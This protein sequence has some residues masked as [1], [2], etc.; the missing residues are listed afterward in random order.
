[1][2]RRPRIFRLYEFQFRTIVTRSMA[3]LHDLGEGG[4]LPIFPLLR[5][6]KPSCPA[7]ETEVPV[8][9]VAAILRAGYI[10]ATQPTGLGAARQLGRQPARQ[11][12]PARQLQLAFWQQLE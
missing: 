2:V 9:V 6:L 1:M 11:Q 8:D 4:V 5:A 10:I 12:L 7:R 3:E